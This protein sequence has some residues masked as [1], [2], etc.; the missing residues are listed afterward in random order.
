MTVYERLKKLRAEKHYS[1]QYVADKVNVSKSTIKRWEDGYIGN[2]MTDKIQMLADV[3]G[4]T[5]AYILGW[6]DGNCDLIS[7]TIEIN[8]RDEK[9]KDLLQLAFLLPP[10]KLSIAQS[11]L[12]ALLE[13]H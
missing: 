4:V 11:L 5:P 3:Y 6:E 10:D 13:N 7:N 12:K 1:L 8:T 9:I 2:V